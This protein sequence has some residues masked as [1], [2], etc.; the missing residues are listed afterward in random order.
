[1]VPGLRLPARRH[2]TAGLGVLVAVM[3]GL[4]ANGCG[5][6][7]PAMPQPLPSN[8]SVPATPSA[9]ATEQDASAKALAA[10]NGYREAYVAASANGNYA[11]AELGRYTADP[12][13]LQAR[14]SIRTQFESGIVTQGRPTWA[15]VVKAIN[16]V[17]RPFTVTIQDCFDQSAWRAVYKATGK[18][19][20]AP[21]QA[22][23]YVI[24]STATLYPDGRWLAN[25][26]TADRSRSC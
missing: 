13:T 18:S 9:N 23:R 7:A 20:A 16:L 15:P 26:S 5:G 24:M 6:K 2:V 19:A 12:L 10:Y 3:I 14:F 17:S 22:M 11:S 4:A 21:N 25:E 8:A 1:M